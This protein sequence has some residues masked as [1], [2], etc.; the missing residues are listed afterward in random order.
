EIPRF[1]LR[2][3]GLSLG[4]SR[5]AR[6]APRD[7]ARPLPARNHPIEAPPALQPR[8]RRRVR[9]RVY[10]PF[11]V[12]GEQTLQARHDP[13]R[14]HGPCLAGGLLDEGPGAHGRPQRRLYRRRG[15][16]LG[17]PEITNLGIM[18]AAPDAA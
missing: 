18:A 13:R 17:G 3:P 8:A 11:R 6:R 10:V 16:V 5:R 4:I 7:L 1:G 9:A 15:V 2:R 12:A 14:A